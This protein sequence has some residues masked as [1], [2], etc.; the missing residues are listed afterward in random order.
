MDQCKKKTNGEKDNQ[1]LYYR[2][3]SPDIIRTAEAARFRWAGHL[4][5]I[6]NNEMPRRTVDSNL[7]GSRRVENK[8]QSGTVPALA[9]IGLIRT[10]EASRFRWPGNLQTNGK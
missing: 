6:G 10:T 8:E 1:E 9:V 3:R 4:Q 2:Y 7:E 5:I